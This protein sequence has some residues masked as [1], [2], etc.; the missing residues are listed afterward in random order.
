MATFMDLKYIY[1]VPAPR[2]IFSHCHI[3]IFCTCESIAHIVILWRKIP[4][5]FFRRFLIFL[6]SGFFLT[7][8]G[9]LW[10][11]NV[12][13]VQFVQVNKR[14]YTQILNEMPA[15]HSRIWYRGKD[16]LRKCWNVQNSCNILQV[17]KL[18]KFVTD[19]S[20]FTRYKRKTPERLSCSQAT[21]TLGSLCQRLRGQKVHQFIN[22]VQLQRIQR[23]HFIL[24]SIWYH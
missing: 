1:F 23:F 15:P 13:S 22:K 16:R 6:C 24:C 2:F 21:M 4:L 12:T 20:A 10:A 8:I 7:S 14:S 11:K 17:S 3:V 18:E 9:G 5:W 19:E